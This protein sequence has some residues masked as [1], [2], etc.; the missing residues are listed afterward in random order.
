[1]SR[2]TVEYK[3]QFACFSTQK[4]DFITIFMTPDRYKAWLEHE[5]KTCPEKIQTIKKL[6]YRRALMYIKQRMQAEYER[7][8][9]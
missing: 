8:Y 6:G 9:K 7:I 1:M 4:K 2:Y 5:Y 3:G